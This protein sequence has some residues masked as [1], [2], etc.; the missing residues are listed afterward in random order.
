MLLND[1]TKDIKGIIKDAGVTQE[2]I[3][4][5]IGLSRQSVSA[6]CY[7][8]KGPLV[9]KT[10]IDVMEALGYDVEIRYVPRCVK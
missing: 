3:A 7:T 6:L 2:E 5:K 9:S 8:R 1:T 4:E 10:L